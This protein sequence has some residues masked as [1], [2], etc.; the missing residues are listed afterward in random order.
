MSFLTFAQSSYKVEEKSYFVCSALSK[1][2][3]NLLTSMFMMY[4]PS[5]NSIQS[6]VCMLTDLKQILLK[7]YLKAVLYLHWRVCRAMRMGNIVCFFLGRGRNVRII[8]S[9]K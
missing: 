2:A 8:Q 6:Y 3:N 1:P 9:C 4:L 7:L 5:Q